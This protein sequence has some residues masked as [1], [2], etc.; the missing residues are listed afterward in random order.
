MNKPRKLDSGE[1]HL[2]DLIVQGR[3]EDSWS[4][5]S[6]IVLSLVRKLPQELV[7]IKEDG[8]LGYVRLTTK[9]QEVYDAKAYYI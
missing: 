5:S 1:Q 6:K 2:L 9:G 7:E 3:M 8:E 4:R